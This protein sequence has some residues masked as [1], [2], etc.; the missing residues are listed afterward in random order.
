MSHYSLILQPIPIVTSL[1][2]PLEKLAEDLGSKQFTRTRSKK[3]IHDFLND[4]EA[5]I[6]MLEYTKNSLKLM[7]FE[8]EDDIEFCVD[9]FMT[10]GVETKFK[11]KQPVSEALQE[12][13]EVLQLSKIRKFSSYRNIVNEF[14]NGMDY[15]HS[16]HH[17]VGELSDHD[18]SDQSE[19][20]DFSDI[21]DSQAKTNNMD[22]ITR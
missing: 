19:P 7:D 13:M 8:L 4:D 12:K 16:D 6:S 15:V 18:H 5:R 21:E 2:L 1:P 3:K 17:T 11:Y 22:F 9:F 20:S 10:V 14:G